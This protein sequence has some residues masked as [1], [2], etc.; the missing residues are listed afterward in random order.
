MDAPNFKLDGLSIWIRDREFPEAQDF[1]DGNWL[2]LRATVRSEHASV[3][4]EGAIL[5]TSDFE[6]FR[7][8]LVAMHKSVSGEA[9]L[10]GYEPNLSVSLKASQLGHISGQIEI[11]HDHLNERHRFE[12]IGLDQTYLPELIASCDAILERHPVMN[13]P[14]A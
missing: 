7:D 3:T 8:Q 9:S 12:V 11:T 5:M 13:R 2:N 14:D 6:R 4:T 1:Y 10:S